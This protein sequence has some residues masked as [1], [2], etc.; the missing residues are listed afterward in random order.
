VIFGKREPNGQPLLGSRPDD[1]AARCIEHATEHGFALALHPDTPV[2]PDE[3]FPFGHN[4]PVLTERATW[5]AIE[6]LV[7]RLGDV[8]CSWVNLRFAM[9]SGGRAVVRYEAKP[10]AEPLAHGSI[11]ALNGGFDCHR[12]ISDEEFEQ[13]HP[14]AQQ[15]KK[16]ER[17]SNGLS[18]GALHTGR[19]G[20]IASLR[21]RFSAAARPQTRVG[22]GQAIEVDVGLVGE[23][24]SE[25]ANRTDTPWWPEH[26]GIDSQGGPIIREEAPPAP[27]PPASP[28]FVSTPFPDTI[29]E[30][31]ADGRG[32]DYDLLFADT[33][34]PPDPIWRRA[35][36][37]VRL[38]F[39]DAATAH[40]AT[41]EL[42]DQALFVPL[43]NVDLPPAFAAIIGA[44]RLRTTP[45]RV[46]LRWHG[47]KYLD[48]LLRAGDAAGFPRPFLA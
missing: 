46:E 23:A 7:R 43:A 32:D 10:D 13:H 40:A 4:A 6:G 9:D 33:G 35:K 24:G 18:R 26:F 20:I 14:E 45:V 27:F 39:Q 11:P 37:P 8:G 38:V 21:R 19:M 15:L 2:I 47:T 41:I 17:Q 29:D 34:V 3:G 1:L 36:Y 25:D 48:A 28:P 44:S 16:R 42:G 5:A 30:T 31:T 22:L 12:L